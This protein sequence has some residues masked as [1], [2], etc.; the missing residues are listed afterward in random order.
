MR[1]LFSLLFLIPALVSAQDSTTVDSVSALA[2]E[3]PV[4]DS[5]KTLKK[6]PKGLAERAQAEALAQK[7]CVQPYFIKVTEKSP[8]WKKVRKLLPEKQ[9]DALLS[10]YPAKKLSAD[11]QKRIFFS[12]ATL[13]S[14]TCV[15]LAD[16]IGLDAL[17]GKDWI[18]RTTAWDTTGFLCKRTLISRVLPLLDSLVKDTLLLRAKVMAYY[19][20]TW[21]ERYAEGSSEQEKVQYATNPSLV[22]SSNCRYADYAT[23]DQLMK[24]GMPK[25]A[26][27]NYMNE[28]FGAPMLRMQFRKTYKPAVLVQINKRLAAI[29][30]ANLDSAS[31][32]LDTLEV[33]F[34]DGESSEMLDSLEASLLRMLAKNPQAIR[35]IK[36]PTATMLL[37]AFDAHLPLLCNYPDIT[38]RMLVKLINDRANN[39]KPIP[40]AEE[41]QILKSCLSPELLSSLERMLQQL[42]P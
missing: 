9:P 2:P 23:A 14:Q 25:N 31:G 35:Q 30:P 4:L 20:E 17:S 13:D 29:T 7:Q 26:C 42:A 40:T 41:I 28:R 15:V 33:L 11:E 36:D 34:G 6:A 22:D 32:L 3:C 38:D 27:S 8:E 5:L 24:I 16:S 10:L 39:G 19:P 37:T 12:K 18:K 21:F 1:V